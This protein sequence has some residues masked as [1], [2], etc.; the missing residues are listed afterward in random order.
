[1]LKRA[2]LRGADLADAD[3]TDALLDG[4]RFGSDARDEASALSQRQPA[5]PPPRERLLVARWSQI[6]LDGVARS[7]DQI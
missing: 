7:R 5:A 4:A 1:M 3:L 2:D 6:E